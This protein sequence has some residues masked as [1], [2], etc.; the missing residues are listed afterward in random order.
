MM[1]DEK[2]LVVG[3]SI[4]RKIVPLEIPVEKAFEVGDIV[5]A[6]TEYYRIYSDGNKRHFW[7][8]TEKFN[9][10]IEQA[11]SSASAMDV[12]GTGW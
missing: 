9:K 3:V 8:V 12:M 5:R 2:F 4:G 10:A 11:V 7:N 1:L 6:G